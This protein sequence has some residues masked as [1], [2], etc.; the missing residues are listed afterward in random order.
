MR[1]QA[2]HACRPPPLRTRDSRWRHIPR[3]PN[4]GRTPP[5]SSVVKKA[6]G[7]LTTL[8]EERA[9]L[10]EAVRRVLQ[11]HVSVCGHVHHGTMCVCVCVRV[12]LSARPSAFPQHSL[13]GGDGESD[14]AAAAGRVVVALAVTQGDLDM[15][16]N[17]ACSLRRSGLEQRRAADVLVFGADE[18]RVLIAGARL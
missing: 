9:S 12:C 11:P 1:K 13:Q 4:E 2:N 16:A 18:V 8:L 5:S 17:F 7:A 15:L 14:P 3:I 10:L 6:E